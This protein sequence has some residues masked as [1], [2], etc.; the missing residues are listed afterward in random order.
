MNHMISNRDDA[1]KLKYYNNARDAGESRDSGRTV[2]STS[3]QLRLFFFCLRTE[4][5]REI[6][7]EFKPPS[8]VGVS[9]VR[10]FANRHDELKSKFSRKYDQ[11][12]KLGEAW[13]LRI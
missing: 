6:K 8:T 4:D 2:I 11:R 1:I 9:Y 5:E 3:W 10:N 13:N 7:S 12:I